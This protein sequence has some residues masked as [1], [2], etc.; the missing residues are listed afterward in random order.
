MAGRLGTST[1]VNNPP[2]KLAPPA[3][4]ALGRLPTPTATLPQ[5]R[6]FCHRRLQLLVRGDV[7]NVGV[8]ELTCLPQQAGLYL[9][10]Q[11]L[12]AAGVWQ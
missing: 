9:I 11:A 7:H 4:E 5:E 3:S 8:P 2:K 1:V 12:H 6:T 10:Q